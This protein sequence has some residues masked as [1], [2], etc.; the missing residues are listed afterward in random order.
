MSAA[1]YEGRVEHVRLAGRRG[2]FRHGVY[3]WL[4]DVDRLPRLPLPLRPFA[5]VRAADHLG[6]PAASLRANVEGFSAGGSISCGSVPQME[7]SASRNSDGG[8]P[9][10]R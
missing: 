10:T 6:D 7:R 2:A 4:V 8:V 5:R 9:L 3:A 1:L